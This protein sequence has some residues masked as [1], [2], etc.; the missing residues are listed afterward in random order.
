MIVFKI[1]GI[2]IDFLMA[3][4]PL[5]SIP[6]D[7]TL[8]DDDFLCNLDNR[9]IRSLG[10]RVCAPHGQRGMLTSFQVFALQIKYFN[11]SQK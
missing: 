3:C 5:S 11:L 8:Q 4:L 2:P 7:L 9:C 10:G 6:D 1:S